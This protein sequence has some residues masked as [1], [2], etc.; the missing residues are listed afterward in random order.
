M[1]IFL[2]VVLACI[3]VGE[4]LIGL[5]IYMLHKRTKEYLY[6]IEEIHE[7]LHDVTRELLTIDKEL[8]EI[9]QRLR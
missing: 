2:I 7:R 6:S 4:V 3:L 9:L 5:S 8:Y 1:S